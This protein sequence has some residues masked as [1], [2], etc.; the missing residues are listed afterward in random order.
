MQAARA[1]ASAN[2]TQLAQL[3]EVLSAEKAAA[4]ELGALAQQLASALAQQKSALATLL[5]ELSETRA[6]S[7][8]LQ[9]E[10][11]AHLGALAEAQRSVQETQKELSQLRTGV[12]GSATSLA[13]TAGAALGMLSNN[14]FADY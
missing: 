11:N 10:A 2:E 13:G 5:S 4:S 8:K 9:S 12:V 7:A 14:P 6:A 3:R 1:A